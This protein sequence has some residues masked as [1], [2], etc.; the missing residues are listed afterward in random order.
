MISNNYR[1][2]K[3]KNPHFCGLWGGTLRS[4]GK[5]V[6]MILASVPA[7]AAANTTNIAIAG[8][9][10]MFFIGISLCPYVTAL[11]NGFIVTNVMCRV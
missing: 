9:T 6:V 10:I 3:Q 4:Y 11:G 5:A 2:H 7:Y 1:K 8:T